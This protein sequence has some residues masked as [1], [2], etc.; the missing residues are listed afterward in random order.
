MLTVLTSIRSTKVLHHAHSK[1]LSQ[2]FQRPLVEDNLLWKTTFRGRHPSVEYD[3]R[4]KT[5][6]R[7]RRPMV[8]DVLWWKTSFSERRPSVEDTFCG[9]RPLV[10]DNLQWKTTFFASLHAAYSALRHFC[11]ISANCVLIFIPL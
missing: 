11:K 7:G 8:E 2:M 4:W 9:R 3:L 5:T 6:F 10:E 1:I